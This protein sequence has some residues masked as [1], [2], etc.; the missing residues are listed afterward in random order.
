MTFG[1]MYES[2]L[3]NILTDFINSFGFDQMEELSICTFG[4]MLVL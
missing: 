2:I 1:P 3:V 4:P